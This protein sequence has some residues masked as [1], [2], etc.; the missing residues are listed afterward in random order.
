[1][2]SLSASCPLG[3]LMTRHLPAWQDQPLN[4]IAPPGQLSLAGLTS[5]FVAP[6]QLWSAD[7]RWVQRAKQQGWASF[8]VSHSAPDQLPGRNLL[9][10]PKSKLEGYWWLKQLATYSLD[11]F[12]LIGENNGG[13][14][15]AAAQL[16]KAGLKVSKVD[17]ARRCGLYWIEVEA[18]L[19]SLAED[20]NEQ[21]IEGPGGLQVFSG[22]GV[23]GQGRI[24]EGSQLLLSSLQEAQTELPQQGRC[25]DLGCGNGLLGAWMLRQSPNLQLLASDVSGFALAA[26]RQTLQANGLVAEV[27]PGDIFKGLEAVCP[28]QSLDWII[29][30]PPFHTG[31]A[32]DY[33]LSQRLIAEAPYFLKPGGQL[34]L[35]A[36]RFLPYPDLLDAAFGCFERRAVT[37]KFTVY[38]SIKKK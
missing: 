6:V 19:D 15:A 21:V 22:P 14:K 13:V 3:Q 38:Q 5:D 7:W 32:T 28:A 17:S 24:D 18:P 9:F 26:T 36:N 16:K 31:T 25:L 8:F 30:N 10:W 29:T 1:M 23:F 11:G 35:V 27:H 12:Y 4:L 33:E 34:W 37:G 2:S 20:L